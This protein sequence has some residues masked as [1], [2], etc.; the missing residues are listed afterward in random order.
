MN[1]IIT[2]C[3]LII[4]PFVNAIENIPAD[5]ETYI[6]GL[7]VDTNH[8]NAQK[9]ALAD[10]TQ[11][12][13]TRVQSSVGISQSKSGNVTNTDTKQ[14]T[15]AVSQEIELPNVHV[16]ESVKKDNQWRV[17]IRVERKLVQLALKQQLEDLNDELSFLLEDFVES[18]GPACWYALTTNNHKKEKLF[19]LIPAY[20]GSGMKEESTVTFKKQA[21]SFDRLLKRCKYKNKYT[22]NYP[23][24]TPIDFKNSFEQL[25]K[26]QGYK[27][28]NQKKNAGTIDVK[29]TEKKTY[30]YKNHLNI[31]SAEVSVL[32]EFG[33]TK[34]HVK[35]KSKGSSFNNKKEASRKAVV[36]L[37]KKI[38]TLIIK[39]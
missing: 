9:L 15:T 12:L 6:Y 39:S 16:L 30:A 5:D 34:K 25:M 13:S 26:K 29:F 22:I 32:D 27:V 23:K 36:N 18:Q 38:E 4:A 8:S 31:I 35:F 33:D 7:G 2:V 19:A 37:I 28:T 14:R 24:Q 17:L 1:K 20:I 10:I 21:T 3:L 11:K